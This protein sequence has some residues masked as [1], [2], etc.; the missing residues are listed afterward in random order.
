MTFVI[1]QRCCNDASCVPVCPVNCIHPAPGEPGYLTTEM[2][3]IDP[4]TCIE[5][6]ACVQVCPVDAIKDETD[7]LGSEQQFLEINAAFYARHPL[8]EFGDAE[9]PKRVDI[10]V[11]G[12]RVAIV[13]S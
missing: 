12:L 7:L 10:D 8:S 5:C 2:L 1:T 6:S 4:E 9:E 11:R 3:Y 13:G